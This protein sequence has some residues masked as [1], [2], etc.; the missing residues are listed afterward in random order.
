MQGYLEITELLK[1]AKKCCLLCLSLL[2]MLFLF[3]TSAL[4]ETS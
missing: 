4:T 3:L 2:Q 1:Y